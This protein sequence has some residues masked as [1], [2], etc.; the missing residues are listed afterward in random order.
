MVVNIPEEYIET[1]S[2]KHFHFLDP[3]ADDIDI[4]DIAFALSNT[5]RYNGHCKTYYSVAEHSMYVS[6]LLP[7]GLRLSGLLHDAAEAY[8]GDIPSPIKRFLPDIRAMEEAIQAAIVAKFK[9]D[10]DDYS[11]IKRA[12]LQQLRTESHF[13]LPSRGENWAMWDTL[14]FDVEDGYEPQGLP[15]QVAFVEFMKMYKELT[16]SKIVLAAA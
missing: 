13:L 2:G 7:D 5:C 3:K 12:D 6:A 15:P 10:V 1:R 9:L 14:K 4:H 11:E 16:E 8:V